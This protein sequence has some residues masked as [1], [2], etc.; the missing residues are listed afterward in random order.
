MNAGA[1]IANG[2]EHSYSRTRAIT[3]FGHPEHSYGVTGPMD[4]LRIGFGRTFDFVSGLGGIQLRASDPRHDGQSWF[5]AIY[6]ADAWKKS[7]LWQRG[8]GG[9]GNY[10][11]LFIRFSPGGRATRADA[12]FKDLDG[13]IADRF[14][15]DFD[16]TVPR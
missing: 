6:A 9:V 10:G 12:Y 16:L 7:G 1:I 11:A 14:S 13:R 5:A 3:D 2:H 4:A 15:I 8:T